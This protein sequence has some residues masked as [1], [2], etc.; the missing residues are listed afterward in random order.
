M[1]WRSIQLIR[2]G[3]ELPLHCLAL[4]VQVGIGGVDYTDA[5]CQFDGGGCKNIF[6]LPNPGVTPARSINSYW[7]PPCR[8]SATRS[9]VPAPTRW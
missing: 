2:R 7:V 4:S 8:S 1:E 9:R 6:A 3:R 5:R